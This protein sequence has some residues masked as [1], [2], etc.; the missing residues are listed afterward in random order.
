MAPLQNPRV[1]LPQLAIEQGRSLS[2]LSATIG[3]N[4]AY[5]RQFVTRGSPRRIPE[6]ERRHLA[7]VLNV[8]DLLVRDLCSANIGAAA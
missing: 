5:L 6:E 8:D 3:R 4:P 1:R 2:S 7:I